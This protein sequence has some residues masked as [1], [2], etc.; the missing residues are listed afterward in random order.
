MAT[1]RRL[2][3]DNRDKVS[4]L[5]KGLDVVPDKDVSIRSR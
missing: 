2:D 1:T 5:D 3:R 4:D